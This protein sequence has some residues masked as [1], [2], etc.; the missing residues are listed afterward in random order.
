MAELLKNAMTGVNIIPTV[1]LGVVL[2]YWLIVIIGVI[3]FEFLDFDLDVD[4]ADQGPFYAILAFLN[5]A[6]VPFML[7]LSIVALNWWIIA[8][9]LCYLPITIGGVVSGIL[10]IPSFG[11]SLV[12]T[13]Y[14]TRP[15]KGIFKHTTLEKDEYVIGQLC[16]LRCDIEGDRLGQAEIERDGA[17]LV[18]NVKAENKGQTFHKNDVALVSSRDREKNIYYIIK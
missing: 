7:V 13:K 17:Q 16:T 6:E 18:I 10:F 11:V 8:M 4:G 2:L 12:I 1:L 9:L 14:V 15:L 5:L 3:D